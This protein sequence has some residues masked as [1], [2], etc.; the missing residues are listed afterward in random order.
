MSRLFVIT[1]GG[2][3]LGHALTKIL[4]DAG[5]RV[6]I[7]G[8]TLEKLE[9]T[10]A[11]NKQKISYLQADISKASGRGQVIDYFSKDA[12]IDG[13]VHNA[14]IVE[15]LKP[16]KELSLEQWQHTQAINVEGPLFL[17]Q[18]LL[19]KAVISKIIHVS[20]GARY[21][22]MHSWSAYCTS[23]AALF[24]LYQCFKLEYPDTSF[25]SVCPGIVDTPMMDTIRTTTTYP[26]DARSFYQ[27]L[28]DKGELVTKEMAASF[29]A[30]LLLEVN[31]ARFSESEWDIY[32][33]S[34]HPY[35]AKGFNIPELE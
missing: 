17:S 20:S 34:H 32:D 8:R 1:G 5:H 14:G 12:K 6:L 22:P 27:G 9:Q 28:Y 33:K 26:S 21:I 18:G 11:Y 31:Q 30:W 25:A 19:K 15:P 29:M 16:I 35:W 4:V 24:M 2:S 10:K 13:L 7:V 3:G 23:K